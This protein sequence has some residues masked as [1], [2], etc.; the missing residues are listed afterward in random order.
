MCIVAHLGKRIIAR[1]RRFLF[2]D[3]NAKMHIPLGMQTM[4][5]EQIEAAA[6]AAGLSIAEVCR[7]AGIAQSTFGRWKAG[8][9]EPTMAVYRRICAAVMTQPESAS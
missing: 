6:D 1:G 3:A 7:R 5:P 2:L 8:R 9:T 4:T